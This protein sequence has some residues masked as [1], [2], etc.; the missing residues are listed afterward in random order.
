MSD[1]LPTATFT[2]CSTRTALF[3]EGLTEY[4]I[5][6]V[7]AGPRCITIDVRTLASQPPYRATLQ[8]GTCGL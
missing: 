4:F 7:V 8:F 5:G 2:G 6:V 1:G 3:G